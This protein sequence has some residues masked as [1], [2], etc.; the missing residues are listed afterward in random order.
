MTSE[1]H[2]AGGAEV[3]IRPLATRDD[4]LAC[5]DLQ[6]RTWGPGFRE[7]VSPALLMVAQKVGGVVAGA[8]DSE[9]R[10]LGFVFG[11]TGVTNGQLCHW[12][13]M[14][15]VQRT[16]RDRG[17][18]ARL[19]A[20]QKR[21]LLRVGVHT[22]FWTFD[23]LVARNAHVNLNRL[24]ARV[25]EYVA[26][27]YG[28]QIK[29][30]LDRGIGTD[31]FVVEWDLTGDQPEPGEPAEDRGAI[32][33]VE[34]NDDSERPQPVVRPFV[35]HPAV[36]VAIPRD[37][38]SVK[39]ADLDLARAWRTATRQAF[40]HYFSHAYRV[41]GFHASATSGRRFYRLETPDGTI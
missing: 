13:H 33:V 39:T 35:A 40:L 12:S 22:M 14:L 18:G 17:I 21:A 7:V 11:M 28:T 36:T 34:A 6:E 9:G 4:Y 26:D 3:A 32:A 15:A 38:Q 5:L 41:V 25:R 30:S 1:L 16:H 8:F 2:P 31:R 23:P 27:F 37:I 20:Y 24:G 29:S 10:M 19:K